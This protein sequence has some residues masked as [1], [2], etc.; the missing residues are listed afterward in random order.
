VNAALWLLWVAPLTAAA[1]VAGGDGSAWARDAAAQALSASVSI[2]D[3][4]RR[5]QSLAEV[6]EIESSLHGAV[7]AVSILQRASDSAGKIDNPSLAGWALHDIAI[8]YVKAGALDEAQKIAETLADAK[9]RDAVLASIV[10]ARRAARD[11]PGALAVAQHM[12]DAGAQGRE[13][14]TL[15]IAQ[16]AAGELDAALET[17]RSIGHSAFNALALGDVVAALAKE[18]RIE[19][20]T[21]LAFRIRNDLVRGDAL[22]DVAAAQL[23]LDDSSGALSTVEKIDDKLARASALAKL[24]EVRASLGAI[25][26]SRELF[27][28][29]IALARGTRAS[30]ERRC[31]AFIDIARSQIAARELPAARETLQLAL[32]ALPGVKRSGARLS[33]LAQL[34]PMQG[35]V[36]DHA[37]AMATAGKAE[38]AS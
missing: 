23:R 21:Q 25:S 8:A 32:G 9:P 31:A 18:G 4:F 16:A 1:P 12:Q 17:A 22:A 33:L 29:S 24:A 27:A 14:R 20:A 5:A 2:E 34:A 35:R 7:A 37:G 13:L 30:A 3:P 26:A 11:I 10:S 36:G 6:A 15:V 38:D 28:R 19:E